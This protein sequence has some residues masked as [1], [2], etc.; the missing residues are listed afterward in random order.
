MIAASTL[1]PVLV[2]DWLLVGFAA[3]A[4]AGVGVM[5]LALG[6][7]LLRAAVDDEG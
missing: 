6:I 5:F 4:L 3:L 2:L 1:S 7:I